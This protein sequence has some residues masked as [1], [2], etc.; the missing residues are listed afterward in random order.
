MFRSHELPPSRDQRNHIPF[1]SHVADAVRI[2]YLY[3]WH[4][5]VAQS[6]ARHASGL[7][8]SLRNTTIREKCGL[9]FGT[10]SCGMRN[11]RLPM[12]RPFRHFW[13]FLDRHQLGRERQLNPWQNSHPQRDR[14]SRKPLTSRL[15]KHNFDT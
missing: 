2:Y 7:L 13:A 10:Q 4:H 11:T 1:F 6:L 9:I 3:N 15:F 8:V 14:D 12:Q 5:H